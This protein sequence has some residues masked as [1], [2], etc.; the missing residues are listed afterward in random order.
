MP[1]V[2]VLPVVSG[3]GCKQRNATQRVNG[4]EERRRKEEGKERRP[5]VPSR[6]SIQ[7]HGG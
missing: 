3:A 4:K 6:V 2:V 1:L 7:Q 5:R